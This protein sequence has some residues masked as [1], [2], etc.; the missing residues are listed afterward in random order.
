MWE[1]D[2]RQAGIPRNGFTTAAHIS[3]DFCFVL[4]ALSYNSVVK[5]FGAFY[6]ISR[7][8]VKT[9]I[10]SMTSMAAWTILLRTTLCK[11]N[12]QLPFQGQCRDRGA[13]GMFTEPVLC[14]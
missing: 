12:S 13:L 4:F 10:S 11:Q 1:A 8:L 9:S 7:K 3:G 14:L 5:L 6:P 2:G